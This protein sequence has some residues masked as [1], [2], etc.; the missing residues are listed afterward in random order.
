LSPL[1]P[2]PLT[3]Y[4]CE[5]ADGRK[6]WIE[7]RLDLQALSKGKFTSRISLHEERERGDKDYPDA[8]RWFG[9]FTQIKVETIEA[10]SKYE[11]KVMVNRDGIWITDWVTSVWK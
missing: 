4:E 2:V 3:I 10:A 6:I 9:P 1:S 7:Q 8:G 5:K 11:V